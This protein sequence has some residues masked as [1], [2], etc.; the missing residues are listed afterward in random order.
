MA[1]LGLA[2]HRPEVLRILPGTYQDIVEIFPQNLPSG[3]GAGKDYVIVAQA[4]VGPHLLA[5]TNSTRILLRSSITGDLSVTQSQ[6]DHTLSALATS[7]LIAQ[8]IQIVYMHR[9]WL[10]G[11]IITLSAYSTA[12][13][14]NTRVQ[15][16]L[17]LVVD[18][19]AL[20]GARV[21]GGWDGDDVVYREAYYVGGSALALSPVGGAGVTQLLNVPLPWSAGTQQWVGFW[22]QLIHPKSSVHGVGCTLTGP[23]TDTWA[24]GP[25]GSVY[26][27]SR[28]PALGTGGSLDGATFWTLGSWNTRTVS[29]GTSSFRLLGGSFY[30]T[31]GD[32]VGMTVGGGLLALNL[33]ALD[34][35][36][37][38]QIDGY[39]THGHGAV[40]WTAGVA[41][42]ISGDTPRDL[43]NLVQLSR[44]TTVESYLTNGQ[45]A[46]ADAFVSVAYQNAWGDLQP[47]VGERSGHHWVPTR[48]RVAI[49]GQVL[50]PAGKLAAAGGATL[51]DDRF[52]LFGIV[53][54]GS[55]S[56][57]QGLDFA[58]VQFALSNDGPIVDPPAPT[59]TRVVI[60][61]NREA[62]L[63]SLPPLVVEPSTITPLAWV[64]SDGTEVQTAGKYRML[65][66]GSRKPRRVHELEWT[67]IYEA[68]FQALYGQITSGLGFRATILP[69]T[70]ER[71]WHFD[72]DTFRES[73]AADGTRTVRVNIVELVYLSP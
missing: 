38:S 36:S 59:L 34:G 30:G 39:T 43:T 69:D 32:P 54:S 63:S 14:G 35:G 48:E 70:V 15:G 60:T 57:Y 46:V 66:G 44:I 6:F 47:P 55:I 67:S 9:D 68:D 20:G 26:Q 45:P 40:Q 24:P 52:R 56:T 53:E 64:D 31:T 3:T 72:A 73:Y 25:W 65:W 8:P 11:E 1:R 17:V 12:P 51:F 33:S 19:N 58:A 2:Y 29:N 28:A 16:V 21:A 37:A 13:T 4:L 27:R 71:A 61:P 50:T 41:R 42:E 22:S 7:R 10:P 18:L 23:T 5:A 49:H 62:A